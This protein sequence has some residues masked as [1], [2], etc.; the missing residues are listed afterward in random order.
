MRTDMNSNSKAFLGVAERPA[1]L[2]NAYLRG[3]Y[4][5]MAAG[6]MVTG[7]A[8]WG[9]ISEPVLWNIA[10]R[11]S[12]LFLIALLIMAFTIG[13]AINR[14]SAGMATVLFLVYCLLF[15]VVLSFEL[16]MYTS[17]SVV[18]TFITCSGMFVG[19]SL[20]G[21]ITKRD[22]TSLGS[23]CMMGLLGIFI[24]ILVSFFWPSGMLNFI[25]CCVGVLVFLGLTAFETQR[26]R[27]F[28][29]TAPE[30]DAV[31]LRRG[32]ILGALRLYL[33]FINLF[34]MLLRLTGDRR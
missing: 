21:L 2:T 7:I 18:Q 13:G 16:S 27:A 12:F 19:M 8:A 1:E 10:E 33:N 3:V 11:F 23:F 5:W 6:L 22:L 14:L 25:I 4:V 30:D 31:A 28:G 26:L 20:Y 24:A 34:M 9:V 29:A 17:A 15:G 32:T